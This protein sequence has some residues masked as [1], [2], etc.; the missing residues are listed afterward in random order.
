ML[1]TLT[2][3]DE[4]VRIEFPDGGYILGDESGGL[5][6][7]TAEMNNEDAQDLLDEYV[8]QDEGEYNLD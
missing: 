8:N 7:N 2:K 5:L 4:T 3:T 6:E 1:I